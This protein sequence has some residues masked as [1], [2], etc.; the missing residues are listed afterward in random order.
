LN[1]VHFGWNN[2]DSIIQCG[3]MGFLVSRCLVDE[4]DMAGSDD[5]LGRSRR[6]GTEDRG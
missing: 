1:I 5:D 6:L 4:C 3:E 2:L